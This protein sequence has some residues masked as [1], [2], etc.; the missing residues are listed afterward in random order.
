MQLRL[1]VLSHKC[2]KILL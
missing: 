2:T 1:Q